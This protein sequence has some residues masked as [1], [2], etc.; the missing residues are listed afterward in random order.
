MHE[1]TGK[2]R[3]VH[4]GGS[5]ESFLV[6]NEDEIRS[7]WSPIAELWGR[8]GWR[9]IENFFG[10]QGSPITEELIFQAY[11]RASPALAKEV[12]PDV[13]VWLQQGWTKAPSVIVPAPQAL[14]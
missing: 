14:I 8:D 13:Q 4:S 6:M 3:S 12:D 5:D 1:D 11:L 7:G 2:L 10:D 9:F